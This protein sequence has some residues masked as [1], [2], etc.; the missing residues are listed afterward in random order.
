MVFLTIGAAHTLCRDSE[1]YTIK[2]KKIHL[3]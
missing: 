1:Q 3:H 2:L